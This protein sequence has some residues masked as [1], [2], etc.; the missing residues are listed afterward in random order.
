MDS[1]SL[2]FTVIIVGIGATASVDL[3]AILQRY[4]FSASPTSWCIVGRWVAYLP[5]GQFVHPNIAQMRPL[6]N[7]CIVGWL[8]HYII[9]VVFAAAFLLFV[10]IEWVEQ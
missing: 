1:A 7:E 2:I 8:T 6:K 3:W 5:R 4:L 10:G 9:G